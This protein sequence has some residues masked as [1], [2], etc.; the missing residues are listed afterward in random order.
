MLIPSYLIAVHK[1]VFVY[2]INCWRRPGSVCM[3]GQ[4]GASVLPLRAAGMASVQA[5]ESGPPW[6]WA[7]P[8]GWGHLSTAWGAAFPGSHPVT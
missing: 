1:I 7:R 6:A 4:G 5:L 3:C 8:A 2:R